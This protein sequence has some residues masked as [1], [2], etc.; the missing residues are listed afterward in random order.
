VAIDAERSAAGYRTLLRVPGVPAQVLLGWVAQLTQP[1][2]P[3][4]TVLVIESATGS[5]ELAG[6]VVAAC[7]VGAAMARPIHGRL[8]DRRGAR[9]VAVVC[10]FVHCAALVALVGLV[11]VTGPDAP[12]G[13][14]MAL[15]WAAGVSLPPISQSMRVDLARRTPASG[16][17]TAYSLVFLTQELS[18]LLGPLLFGAVVALG[19]ASAALALVAAVAGAGTLA[20]AAV[21]RADRPAR[22]ERGSGGVFGPEMLMLFAVVGL[23]GGVIGA[24]QVGLPALAAELDRPAIAG[25][26]VG[27]LSLGGILGALGHG[28][29]AWAARPA[30][31][32]V[33]LLVALGVAFGPVVVTDSVPLVGL[34]VLAGGVALSPALTATSLLVDELAPAAPGEAF[35]WIST[36]LG[37]GLAAG[38]AAAGVVGQRY[39]PAHALALAAVLP[40]AAAA[41]ANVIRRRLPHGRDILM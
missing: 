5:L 23:L 1:V 22:L 12:G 26:L 15:S 25:V 18:Y 7:A 21:L 39:G 16:R 9:P 20:Y 40:F 13:P 10:G 24:L 11:A 4:G 6:I 27:A 28:A 36:A 41:V 17:T 3:I 14:L 31:R 8:I 34:S 19:N 30:T 2:A 37:L 38:A 33:V 32:L 29:R 35:G